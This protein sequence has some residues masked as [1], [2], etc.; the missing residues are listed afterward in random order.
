MS[1]YVKGGDYPVFCVDPNVITSISIR[2]EERF[3]NGRDGRPCSNAS[4]DRKGDVIP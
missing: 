3:E 4:R 1:P 2:S